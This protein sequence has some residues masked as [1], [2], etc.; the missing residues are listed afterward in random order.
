MGSLD[1]YCAST[2]SPYEIMCVYNSICFWYG[3]GGK[4]VDCGLLM[5]VDMD[6]KPDK[7]CDIQYCC[8]LKSKLMIILKL[9]KGYTYVEGENGYNYGIFHVRKVLKDFLIPWFYKNVLVCANSYLSSVICANKMK[10][11]GL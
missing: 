6:S 4:Y 8:Y 11:L 9:V 1:K 5:Y 2:Y 3:L 10:Q 7:V